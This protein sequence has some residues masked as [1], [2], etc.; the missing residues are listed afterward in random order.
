M[1]HN[2]FA[3]ESPMNYEQKCPCVL[4]LDVSGSMSGEPIKQLNEGLK[5]FQ[6]EI[7]NDETA[8]DRLEVSIVTFGSSIEEVQPFSLLENFD[9]PELQISGSTRLVDGALEGIR[10]IEERKKWYKQTGQTY[11]RP[12]IILMTDGFPDSGQDIEG[13]SEKVFEGVENKHFN[14]WAF[15]VDGADMNMLEK[16][17]HN[18]FKPMKLKGLDFTKF[19]KWLSSSMS[20]ITASHDGDNID[21]SPSTEDENPFQITL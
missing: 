4:V 8:S 16:I 9:M 7:L 15:G 6:Q 5:E 11:Y 12:Y 2:D 18:Q 17:S 13:L 19:F 20:T 14:F 10:L 21:I 1:A 3:G